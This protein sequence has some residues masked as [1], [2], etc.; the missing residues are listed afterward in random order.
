MKRLFALTF[1]LLAEPAFADTPDQLYA[2]GQYDEAIAAGLAQND[3]MGLAVAARSA[4]AQESSRDQPCLECLRRAEDYAKRAAIADPKLPDARVYFAVS[5]GLE[6]HIIG[7]V[8]SRLY[9][10][11]GKAKRALDAAL[12]ADPKNAWA[13]AA[14][15]GWNIAIVH[16][17]GETL[18]RLFYGATLQQGLDDFA[19]A[20]KL[21]PDNVAVRYQYALSLSVYDTDRFRSEIE[22][23]LTRAING[24]PDSVFSRLEQKRA[25]ELLEL[26]KKGDSA[27]YAARLRKFQGY[28]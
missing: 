8:T 27:T 6:S 17:G 12:A 7:P 18:A 3:A 24:T 19:A 4:L 1:L 16:G 25:G 11:P 5:L 2:E 23:T 26:L 28:P 21:A 20:F 15:G 13:L 9:G 10:Y 14:M 22:D